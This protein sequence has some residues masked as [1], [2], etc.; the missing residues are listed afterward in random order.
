MAK[1]IEELEKELEASKAAAAAAPKLSAD[2]EKRVQLR[3]EAARNRAR[4]AA[5]AKAV[6]EAADDELFEELEAKYSTEQLHRI[7]TEA[8][9]LVMRTPTV[10]KSRVFQQVALKGKISPDSIVDFVKPC[11]V[12]PDSVELEDLL[13]RYP[14]LAPQLSQFA[15][16]IGS[17]EAKRR[18]K[19]S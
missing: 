16:E 19:K 3:A 7:D 8:G 10:A 11:L 1:S 14:L 5:A 2:A 13:D 12:H 18:E 17:A 15:Q 6:Q 4:A 9:M